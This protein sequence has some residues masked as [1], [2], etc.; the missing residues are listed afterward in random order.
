[1]DD[2][3]RPLTRVQTERRLLAAILAITVGVS[4][5]LL[6]DSFSD[7]LSK[8]RFWVRERVA[9]LT[10]QQ[11]EFSQEPW[12]R[13]PASERYVFARDLAQRLRG[14]SHEQVAQLVGQPISGES[15]L[16]PLRPEGHTNLWFVLHVQFAGGIVS[17]AHVTLAWLDP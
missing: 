15:A 3:R 6:R 17:N 8:A 7:A 12:L 2:L 13:T 9:P 4:L 14:L 10:W 1:V 11:R 16:W 5:Y